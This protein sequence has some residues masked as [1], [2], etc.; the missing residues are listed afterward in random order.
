MDNKQNSQAQ[1][2]N[3]ESI[4]PPKHPD[5]VHLNGRVLLRSVQRNTIFCGLLSVLLLVVTIMLFDA[6]TITSMMFF[7]FIL[8]SVLVPFFLL[9]YLI[10]VCFIDGAMGAL[11]IRGNKNQPI[12]L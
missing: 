3:Q 8:F 12:T 7:G 9:A 1:Q 6:G 10:K 5:I 11:I 4:K 2:D